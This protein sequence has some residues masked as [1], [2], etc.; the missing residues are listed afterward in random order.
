MIPGIGADVSVN[1]T[2]EEFAEW[3]AGGRGPGRAIRLQQGYAP[4]RD[5]LM[6]SAIPI[7]G[8]QSVGS[9]IWLIDPAA[10]PAAI[11]TGRLRLLSSPWSFTASMRFEGGVST[12]GLGRVQSRAV[13]RSSGQRLALRM[14]ASI[15]D[16]VHDR[17]GTRR[18]RLAG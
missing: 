7:C 3:V 11:L 12:S 14:L 13:A 18:A 5:Y 15:A 17:A 8:P 9:Q 2:L 1:V 4:P 10:G 16:E 6:R